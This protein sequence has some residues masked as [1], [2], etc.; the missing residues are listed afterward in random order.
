MTPNPS[1][2]EPIQ[3]E[4]SFPLDSL[5]DST[6]SLEDLVSY[7]VRDSFLYLVCKRLFDIA[8]S[9]A[10]ILL[11]LPLMIPLALM[12]RLES[13]GP[14][15]FRQIRVGKNRKHF[16]CFKFRSM[17]DNAEDMKDGLEALNEAKGPM[18]KIQDDPRI[19]DLGSFLRRSSLDELPQLFNVLKG[20]MS[21]VGPRPQIPSE[22]AD[23]EPWHYRRLEVQPGITCLWQ[24]SGRSSIGFNEWMRLDSEYVRNRNFLLDLKILLFTLPA[25]IARRGAY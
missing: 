8:G 15:F 1:P 11:F 23:Y 19:T 17:V 12:I 13:K 20:D 22:V 2:K 9:L 14:I 18:F 4:T 7:P 10:G 3:G 21:I 25:I 6:S 16:A 5:S 24:I